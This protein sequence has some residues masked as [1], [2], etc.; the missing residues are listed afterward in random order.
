M[1]GFVTFVRITNTLNP[2]SIDTCASACLVYR[3]VPFDKGAIQVVL[4]N[5]SLSFIIA[6]AYLFVIINPRR[7]I[8]CIPEYIPM[9]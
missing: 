8:I 4:S 5:R 3:F 9:S 6:P 1:S 2:S 7:I